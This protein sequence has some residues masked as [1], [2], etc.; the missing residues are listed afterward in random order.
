M[1]TIL[2]VDDDPNNRLLLAS[3]LK[4]AAHTVLQAENGADG[5]ELAAQHVPD[6][7]IV[8]LCM[9]VVDG[10]TFVRRLRDDPA[11][12]SVKI[13]ISTGTMMTA[14]IEDFLETYRVE[15]I[16]PKPS[17]PQEILERV[18]TALG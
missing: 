18:R 9:P 15:A 6:L 2:V 1:S 4:Y 17:E 14:A 16:I 3:L 7:A 13:A 8:D 11:L 10:V 5:L 12:A